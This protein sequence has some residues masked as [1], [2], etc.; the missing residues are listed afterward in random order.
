[1][2]ERN[3]NLSRLSQNYLF[4]DIA[5]RKEVYLKSHPDTKLINLGV[6]DTTQPIPGVAA[7]AISEMALKL[8]TPS[9]Y[10]G[11]GEG[12]GLGELRK[13]IATLFY[14]DRVCP[15]EVF[16][17][18]GAKCDLGRLQA[19]F[20]PKVSIAVQDPTYP[21]YVD[22]SVLQGVNE[23]ITMPCTAENNFFPDFENTPRTDLI[24]FCSPNNPTGSVATAEQLEALISFAKMNG[25]IIIFDAAY[26][27]YIQDPAIPKSIFD[28]P[29][30]KEVAIEVNSFSKMAGFTGVRLG[31]T[32]VPE[33][34]KYTDGKSVHSD[35]KRVHATIFNAASNVV[36]PGGIA[37]LTAEG[38]A[39]MHALVQ[40]YMS[41]AQY[42]KK[43]LAQLGY[44]ISGGEHAPYLWIRVPDGKTSWEF[45][46]ALLEKAGII[47]IPGSGFGACG[48]GYLRLSA[49]ASEEDIHLAAESFSTCTFTD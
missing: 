10:R 15:D 28:V 8:A 44:T 1:M 3:P 7:K 36:Q 25:S 27:M 26:A 16:V 49:F 39:A 11:Y 46:Q 17:S 9:G 37:L 18:D 35:W 29:G 13:A 19:L 43:T 47:S 5:K 21:V 23:I 45:F 4:A 48:E 22:G 42:L 14:R 6:G 33:E 24:Y 12:E 20:G 32:V 40:S 41:R 30:A 2:V 34:L 31:W 38:E